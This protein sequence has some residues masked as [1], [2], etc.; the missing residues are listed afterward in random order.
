LKTLLREVAAFV[1]ILVGYLLLWPVP[2]DPVAWNAPQNRGYVDPYANNDMLQVATGIDLGEFEGPEDATVGLDGRLYAT[3]HHGKV[4]RIQNRAISVYADVGGRPL[5]IQTDRDGSLLIANAYSGLQ[6]VTA[7]GKVITLLDNIDGEPLVYA[8]AVDIGPDGTIYFSNASSK[9]GAEAFGGTYEAS[10]LDIVEHGGHGSLYAFDPLTKAVNLLLGDINFANGVAVSED[11]EFVLVAETGH[12]R[13]LKHWLRGDK[14]GTTDVLVD[15]L[16]G[17]PDNIKRGTNG[18]FWIGLVS[19][20]SKQLD[21][22]SDKPILRKIVQRL[23]AAA[24]PAAIPFSHVIAINGVGQVLMN[25][26]DSRSRFPALTG[27]VETR[28]ALYLTNLFGRHLGRV[29]KRDL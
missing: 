24:R 9:F 14:A 1:G 2:V 3:T 15:N 18:R 25:L 19:P 26:Q 27:V 13:I 7:D 23:P 17:F 6:R 12:Y 22:M 28:D 11:G 10:L 21:Q 4:I 16:P 5:G 8:D 20:R 29:A